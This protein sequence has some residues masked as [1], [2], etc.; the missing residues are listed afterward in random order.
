M[1]TLGCWGGYICWFPL[2][3]NMLG[4]LRRAGGSCVFFYGVVF[5]VGDWELVSGGGAWG[6][7]FGLS[8]EARVSGST[9]VGCRVVFFFCWGLLTVGFVVLWSFWFFVWGFFG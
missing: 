7:F 4:G 5:L 2:W 9:E 6:G 1:R 3:C 8:V